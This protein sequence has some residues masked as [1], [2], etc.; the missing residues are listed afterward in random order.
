MNDFNRSLGQ[1]VAA[2]RLV[3]DLVEVVREVVKLD[4]TV[5]VEKAAQ[6]AVGATSVND[7]VTLTAHTEMLH[8]PI[9][10]VPVNEEDFTTL[11]DILVDAAQKVVVEKVEQCPA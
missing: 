6:D 10:E 5:S 8:L 9:Y 7:L 3:N 1:K 4:P 2:N 11:F